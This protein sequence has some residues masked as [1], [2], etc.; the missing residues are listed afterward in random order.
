MGAVGFDFKDWARS[1]L[2]VQINSNSNQS[3]ERNGP[4]EKS[5][6][7]LNGPEVV[8]RVE[9]RLTILES[10]LRSS[11]GEQREMLKRKTE[12]LRCKLQRYY[13]LAKLLPLSKDPRE[14]A[15]FKDHY[16]RQRSNNVHIKLSKEVNESRQQTAARSGEKQGSK[17]SWVPVGMPLGITVCNRVWSRQ[18]IMVRLFNMFR[19]LDLEEAVEVR[20]A[21]KVSQ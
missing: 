21:T 5:T 13:F 10:C 17:G 1:T 15:A 2:G 19:M 7:D 9:K 8:K 12:L 20:L 6:S 11:G 4:L 18:Q 3:Q 14:L 16:R